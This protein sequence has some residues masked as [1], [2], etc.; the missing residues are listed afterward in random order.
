MGEW[1]DWWMGRVKGGTMDGM[2]MGAWA[3]RRNGGWDCQS[4]I[5]HG[6]ETQRKR[7]RETH[8]CLDI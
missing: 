8:A 3:E 2:R 1:V 6:D 4:G 7:E 5:R